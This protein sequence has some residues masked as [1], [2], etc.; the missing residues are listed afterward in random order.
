MYRSKEKRLKTIQ[1]KFTNNGYSLVLNTYLYLMLSHYSVFKQQLF[2]CHIHLKINF[3]L[4]NRVDETAVDEIGVD[5]IAVDKTGVDGP[6][7]YRLGFHLSLT[8]LVLQ[9]YRHSRKI[10]C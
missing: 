3:G 9:G 10:S 2:V 6:G 8:K 5:K 1:Q 4:K 7:R